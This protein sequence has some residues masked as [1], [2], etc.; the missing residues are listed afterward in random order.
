MKRRLTIRTKLAVTLAVPLVALASFAAFQVRDAYNRCVRI[1][2]EA[3]PGAVDDALLQ[4]A[5][6][7]ELAAA[8]ADPPT[9]LEAAAALVPPVNRFFEDVLV[10]AP[11][12]AVRANRLTLVANVAA[13]L[14][15][16]SDFGQLPG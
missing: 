7:R 3:A 8:I 14:G 16:L 1:A 11:D 5:A 2:G 13:A 12:A 10:M 9:T 4:D 6:E 15:R